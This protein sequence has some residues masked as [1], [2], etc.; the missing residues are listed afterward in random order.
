MSK[1]LSRQYGCRLVAKCVLAAILY[2][3]LAFMGTPAE[4]QRTRFDPRLG[5]T[6]FYRSRVNYFG[7]QARDDSSARLTL[8]LPVITDF[9]TGSLRFAYQTSFEK[10]EEFTELDDLGHRLRLDIGWQ[11]TYRS[12]LNLGATY[13]LRRDQFDTTSLDTTELVAFRQLSR[14]QLSANLGLSRR[15][16]KRWSANL[17]GR[18]SGWRFE[19]Y[20]DVPPEVPPD[21]EDRRE[22]QGGFGAQRSLSERSSL[23]FSFGARLFDLDLSG[24]QDAVSASLVYGREIIDKSS[25]S[26]R[27]GGFRMET[28]QFIDDEQETRTGVQGSLS[29]NRQFRRVTGTLLAGHAPNVGGARIG[30]AVVSY[31]QLGLSDSYFRNWGWSIQSRLGYRDPNDPNVV[32]V[33][34][35]ATRAGINVK[36]HEY[37]GLNFGLTWA[38]QLK[39]EAE[40][41]D[42]F[43]RVS[44]SLV[45]HPFGWTKLAAEGV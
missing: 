38:D 35:W 1:M 14:E 22:L 34:T 21:T 23:G 5:L 8:T 26:L 43:F 16:G 11:P 42:E 6:Y 27:I 4:A 25:I 9:K 10:F 7:E 29:I 3:S 32:V 36:A 17:A 24:R 31:F 41:G 39:G 44:A 28:G 37:L 18:V 15:L 33:Q 19:N 30:T 2:P 13:T 45:W 12:S 20:V 40:A